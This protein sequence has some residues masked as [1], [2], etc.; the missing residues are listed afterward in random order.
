MLC[1]RTAYCSRRSSSVCVTG[2][3]Q[4]SSSS[5]SVVS[6][7]INEIRE[8]LHCILPD[9][10]ES[11]SGSSVE[12][13]GSDG[14][15]SEES[16]QELDEEESGS[17]TAADVLNELLEDTVADPAEGEDADDGCGTGENRLGL[18]EA[19]ERLL[20]EVEALGIEAPVHEQEALLAD[21]EGEG[22]AVPPEAALPADD[23]R[24]AAHAP[25]QRA[26][27]ECLLPFVLQEL[28][29]R[30]STCL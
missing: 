29:S 25:R 26:L 13:S 15:E 22:P 11:D 9:M 16:V 23:A 21:A 20:D 8:L 18:N 28:L 19:M 10:Q 24:G 17:P 27:Q 2:L 1:N 4:S 5:I 30:F 14:E 12:L 7:T 6:Q 3:R